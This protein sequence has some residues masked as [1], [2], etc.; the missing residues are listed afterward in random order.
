M[1]DDFG[2]PI[3]EPPA[4]AIRPGS[5]SIEVLKPKGQSTCWDLD[6]GRRQSPRVASEFGLC[7]RRCRGGVL[8]FEEPERQLLAAG[9]DDKTRLLNA[10]EDL[11]SP[12]QGFVG[13]PPKDRSA[14]G[15]ESFRDGE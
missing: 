10:S 6:G 4:A 2:Q 8:L 13:Q 15:Q 3:L 7:W 11:V 12:A 14:S 1:V 9:H 5:V